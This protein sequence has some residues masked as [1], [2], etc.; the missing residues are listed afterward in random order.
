[1]AL[2]LDNEPPSS[3]AREDEQTTTKNNKMRVKISA[4]WA[5]LSQ[6]SQK[7]FSG[8][9][10]LWKTIK[11]SIS[12]SIEKTKNFF[13]TIIGNKY[14]PHFTMITLFLIV[15]F[16]NLNDRVQAAYLA[17]DIN[18]LDPDIELS[19]T[20]DID[21]FTPNI[22]GDATYVEKA[23]LASGYSEG[24]ATIT[25]PVNTQITQRTEPLPDNS[26][27]SVFYIV[28]SGDTLSSLGWKFG[29][30]LATLKYVND[31]SVD[32][33]KPGM[34]LKVPVRG[35]EV[36]TT[37]IAKKESE[38]K[39]KLAISDRN[40][41]TRNSTSRSAASLLP[42]SSKNAYPFGWCTYY[43]A[44]RR[45]IP[46]HWGNAGQWLSSAKRDGYATGS[47][48]VVGAVVVTSES[49]WGHV[50]YVESV[51]GGEITISEMNAPIWG[52]RTSRT[53]NAHER[54]IKGYIY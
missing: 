49:F 48:P 36:S 13:N 23:N 16:S 31:M 47:N 37:L 44:T 39:A 9:S 45:A 34:R 7:T 21:K 18:N 6:I 30:K 14:L 42:G 2:L 54:K 19:I 33:I 22:G 27:D 4:F 12:V 26:K 15:V 28:R 41:I 20:D 5:N 38:R 3:R 40:T 43:V 35:Y 24:F 11:N 53:I 32:L 51:N 29:I 17:K 1:M 8:F 50:A 52:V 25:A 46:G 10:F